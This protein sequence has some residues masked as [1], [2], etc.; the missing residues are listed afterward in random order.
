ML[1]F[2]QAVDGSLR[3]VVKTGLEPVTFVFCF[4]SLTNTLP[5]RHL[6]IKPPSIEIQA[7]GYN[8][9]LDFKGKGN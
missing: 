4:L 2:G 9:C 7:G 5:L 8:D 6:T 1:L 3:A